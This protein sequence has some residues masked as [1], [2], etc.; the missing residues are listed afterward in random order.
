MDWCY[1]YFVPRDLTPPNVYCLGRHRIYMRAMDLN[2]S[3]AS[4]CSLGQHKNVDT[5]SSEATHPA[6]QR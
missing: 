2:A 5:L 6:P 1:E 3:H 4:P